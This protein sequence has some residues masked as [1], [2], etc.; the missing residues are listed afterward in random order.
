MACDD[1]D[2]PIGFVVY[3]FHLSTWSPAGYC[4]LEDLFVDPELRAR[5]AGRALVESVYAAARARGAARVYWVTQGD[6]A[7][8][9]ALYD[10]IATK[11]TFVQYRWEPRG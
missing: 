10:R 8:A 1:D 11:T 4:Y 5:G 9:Q 2:R 7:R 3:H 6:N